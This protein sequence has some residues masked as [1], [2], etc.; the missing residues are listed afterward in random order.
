MKSQL[1]I[2]RNQAMQAAGAWISMWRRHQAVFW[3]LGMSIALAPQAKAGL[4]GYY[5]LNN[6]TLTNTDDGLFPSFTNGSAVTPDGGL[7]AVLTGGGSGSGLPGTTDLVIQAIGTGLVQ[8]QYSYFSLDVPSMFNP[9]CGPFS[10]DPC[11]LA[12]Y[13]LNGAY[14][15][16]ADDVNQQPGTTFSFTVNTGDIFGFRVET[17]DNIGEPGILTVSDFSAPVPEPGTSSL[18]LMALATMLAAGKRSRSR[19][20]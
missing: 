6:W 17:V 12:G 7:S 19:R 18:L 1:R 4:I 10:T 11:D 14:T 9:G 16:L 13:L 2:S 15:P 20:A 8:F 5:N 3:M